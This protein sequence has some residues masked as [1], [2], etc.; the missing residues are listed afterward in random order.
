M[1]GPGTRVDRVWNY[2]FIYTIKAFIFLQNN[3]KSSAYVEKKM[4]PEI[5]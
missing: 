1:N 4:S 2:F 3:S 5:T